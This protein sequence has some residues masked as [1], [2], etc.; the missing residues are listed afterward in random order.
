[1]NTDN[2]ENE[3]NGLPLQS[4]HDQHEEEAEST[5]DKTFIIEQLRILL[6]GAQ[7]LSEDSDQESLTDAACILWDIRY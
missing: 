6:E 7:S 2:N 3:T 4:K 5:I 1:M